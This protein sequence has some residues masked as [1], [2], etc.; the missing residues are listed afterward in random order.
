VLKLQPDFTLARYVSDAPAMGRE[1]R[2][3]WAEALR[4]AG[5]PN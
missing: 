2:R 3:R 5:A 1:M 4:E